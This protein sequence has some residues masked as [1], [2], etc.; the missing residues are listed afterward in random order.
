MPVYKFPGISILT[1]FLPIEIL[2]AIG[3]LVF[4]QEPA[5]SNRLM[6]IATLILAFVA[7]LP[8]INESI[9]QTPT[10]KLVDILIV[11]HL[12]AILLLAF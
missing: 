9:P 7:F 1:I 2:G 8:T 12:T 10:I 6:T 11:L 4:F 5:L 3:L